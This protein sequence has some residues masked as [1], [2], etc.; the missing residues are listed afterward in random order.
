MNIKYK[1]NKNFFNKKSEELYYFLGFIAA[2]GYVTYY[3]NKIYIGP[4]LRILGNQK[5]LDDLN[6]K[7]KIL[8]KHKVIGS[9]KKEMKMFIQ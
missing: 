7:T 8:Y 9:R 3:K 1:I 6:N 2:D 4:R 5:F